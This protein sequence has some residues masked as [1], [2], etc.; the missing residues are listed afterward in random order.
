M[1]IFCLYPCVLSQASL[2]P[3]KAV[4]LPRLWSEAASSPT[5][6]GWDVNF[7]TFD[8]AMILIDLNVVVSVR[9]IL[10]SNS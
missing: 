1:N 4:M 7:Y 6:I 9:I 8:F 10:L 3:L 2:T 5:F